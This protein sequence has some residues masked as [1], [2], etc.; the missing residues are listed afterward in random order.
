MAEDC[1]EQSIAAIFYG[2]F[3]SLGEYMTIKSI[4]Q[5]PTVG[6]FHA[7]V[8]DIACATAGSVCGAVT[9]WCFGVGVSLKIVEG[10]KWSGGSGRLYGKAQFVGVITGYVGVCVGSHLGLQIADRIL[11]RRRYT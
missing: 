9:G 10:L 5:K 1:T 4:E 11:G 7:T 6:V 3:K 2:H 8:F